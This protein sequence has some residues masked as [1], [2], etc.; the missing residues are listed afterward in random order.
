MFV[1]WKGLFDDWL[2]RF[3]SERLSWK[4]KSCHGNSQGWRRRVCLW[5][6]AWSGEMDIG[7]QNGGGVR[8]A[9]CGPVPFLLLTKSLLSFSS[10]LPHCSH[11]VVLKWV[12][13]C[14]EN[15]C[16]ISMRQLRGNSF[17]LSV[18]LWLYFYSSFTSCIPQCGHIIT[19]FINIGLITWTC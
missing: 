3:S 17:T 2:R 11:V 15:K 7:R 18:S 16:W 4:T 12:G 13:G 14:K 1:L 6:C 10:C 19:Q 8:D 5:C 9:F